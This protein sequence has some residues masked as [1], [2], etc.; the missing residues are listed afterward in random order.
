MR[1]WSSTRPGS[2]W[3]SCPCL[4]EEGSALHRSTRIAFA[5]A[6]TVYVVAVVLAW[7]KVTAAPNGHANGLFI[8]TV[9][10]FVGLVLMMLWLQDRESRC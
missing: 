6:W 1:D 4:H 3:C 7:R 2:W 9:C 5:V 8:A 10:G